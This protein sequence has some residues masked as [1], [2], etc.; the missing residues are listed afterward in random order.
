MAS[1]KEFK[2]LQATGQQIF[3]HKASDHKAGHKMYGQ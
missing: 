3:D 2:S 1:H